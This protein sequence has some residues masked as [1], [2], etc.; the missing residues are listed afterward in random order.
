MIQNCDVSWYSSTY[1]KL[2]ENSWVYVID[3]TESAVPRLD[4]QF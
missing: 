2:A 3:A 4:T 1:S